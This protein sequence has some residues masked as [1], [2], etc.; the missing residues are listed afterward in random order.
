MRVKLKG[1]VMKNDTAALYRRWGYK[2]NCCP[3]DVERVAEG[4]PD[5][6]ELIFELNSPGG[7][8]Y[9]G[10]EMYSAIRQHK[11]RTV[12]EVYGIA[13]S[14]ASVILAACD[15]VKMSPVANVMIHRAS[16][17]AEGNRQVMDGTRQML[18][19]ID[20]SILNAYEEKVGGKTNRE[21]LRAY[22]EQESFFTAS[23]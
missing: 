21:A 4:C 13:G 3:A 2:D 14:A 12:A 20:E 23:R 10:F 5:G 9:A 16:T 1:N 11:G 18:D 6:E 7:S 22:M 19:T 8:V 15:E 17:C